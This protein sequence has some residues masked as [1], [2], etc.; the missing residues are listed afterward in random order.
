DD[1]GRVTSY[2]L[3]QRDPKRQS[4]LPFKSLYYRVIAAGDSYNDTTMLGEADAGILFHAPDNV[5]R[6]FPQ[7]PAV[8]SFEAL[9]QE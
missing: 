4:V 6:E 1:S 7:F 3:R 8:H 9:K 2:Q 5:I